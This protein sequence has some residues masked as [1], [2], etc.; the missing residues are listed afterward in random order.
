MDLL[1]GCSKGDLVRE[2]LGPFGDFVIASKEH[3][4]AVLGSDTCPIKV[5]ENGAVIGYPVICESNLEIS[6]EVGHGSKEGLRGLKSVYGKTK[7]QKR[8]ARDM[9]QP[10]IKKKSS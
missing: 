3:G 5:F 7:N 6:M 2:L 9:K 10:W 8:M 4:Q 1:L